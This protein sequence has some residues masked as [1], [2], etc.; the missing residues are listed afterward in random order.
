V[1]DGACLSDYANDPSR[2]FPLVARHEVALIAPAWPVRPS[3]GA[4]DTPRVYDVVAK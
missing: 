3:P 2:D 1:A 4:S